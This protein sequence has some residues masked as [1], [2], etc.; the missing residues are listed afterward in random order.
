MPRLPLLLLAFATLP[1]CA[2][3]VGAALGAGVVHAVSED[4]VEVLFERS[5]EEVYDVCE[6][7]IERA[8]SVD[9]S[10]DQRGILEGHI[11]DAEVWISVEATRQG[12]QRVSVKARKLAGVSP[13]LET[14]Q[15]L[16]DSIS[17]RLAG[18]S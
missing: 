8:G 14:A 2:L 11:D 3:L 1:G 16:A 6:A 9:L 17:R 13:A 7:Q 5:F 12:L 10:D 15:W 18:A 4:T